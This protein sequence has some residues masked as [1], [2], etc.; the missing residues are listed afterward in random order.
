MTAISFASVVGVFRQAYPIPKTPEDLKIC[1]HCSLDSVENEISTYQ[2]FHC[3]LH[4]DLRKTLFIITNERNALSTNYN[5][6][7]IVCFLFNNADSH[8][9][10]LT[11]YFVFQA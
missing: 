3:D 8:I 7:A 1:D 2:L 11:A 6:N 10:R 5:N 9:S 4:D